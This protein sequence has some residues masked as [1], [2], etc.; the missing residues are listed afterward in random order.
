MR[1]VSIFSLLPHHSIPWG[2]DTG[3]RRGLGHG[4]IHHSQQSQT[5]ST[6]DI[7]LH[8]PHSFIHSLN[9]GSSTLL[10][11]KN[12]PPETHTHHIIYYTLRIMCFDEKKKEEE[13]KHGLPST[14]RNR[15]QS[16]CL[17]HSYIT[18]TTRRN[19][20]RTEREK[21]EVNNTPVSHVRHPASCLPLC[22][23]P[24][25]MNTK[26]KTHLPPPRRTIPTRTLETSLLTKLPLFPLQL[27]SKLHT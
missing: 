10:T 24:Y 2:R 15:N 25:P 21:T 7:H 1:P 22:L 16:P 26:K 18:L 6:Y 13:N 14:R 23:Y 5:H 17:H 19:R 27:K 12:K 11:N 20:T 3:H 9:S 8:S 4:H